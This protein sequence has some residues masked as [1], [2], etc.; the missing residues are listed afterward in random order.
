[1]HEWNFFLQVARLGVGWVNEYISPMGLIFHLFEPY[2]HSSHKNK[3]VHIAAQFDISFGSEVFLWS[4]VLVDFRGL[5]YL[6]HDTKVIP[7]LKANYSH[8][9]A[10]GTDLRGP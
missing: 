1:M 4:N 3:A 9:E 6:Q 8:M 10:P 2:L 5:P 7:F